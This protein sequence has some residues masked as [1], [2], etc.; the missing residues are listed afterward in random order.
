MN[1]ET[2]T[3]MVGVLLTFALFNTTSIILGYMIV[4]SFKDILVHIRDIK[5]MKE[6]NENV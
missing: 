5:K 2:I 3:T 1:I 6:E 4:S